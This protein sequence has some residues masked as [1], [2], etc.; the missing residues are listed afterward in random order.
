MSGAERKRRGSG[1]KGKIMPQIPSLFELLKCGVHFGHRTSKRH[2]K[3]EPYIYTA[4]NGVHIINLEKTQDLLKKALE[5]TKRIA[6][7]GGKILFLGTKKQIQEIVK[8]E[9]KEANMPYVIERWLGGTIT[10]WEEISKLIKKLNKLEELEGSEDFSNYTKKEQQDFRLEKER[11]LL[12]V[13]GIRD[14]DRPP[15]ALFV[16]DVVNEKTAVREAQRKNVPIIAICDSNADPTKITY[17]IPAND[18]AVKSVSLICKLVSEA[19][20][21]GK[22]EFAERQ[23][24]TDQELMSSKEKKSTE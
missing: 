15:Q 22:K 23:T 5:F 18:D 14:L 6:S 3:M 4:R 13:G 21:E 16:V 7:E 9:A 2:P 24:K 12:L 20:K 10:N 1:S 19:I 17:P 8:D 11:L